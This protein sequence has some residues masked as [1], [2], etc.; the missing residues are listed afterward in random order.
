MTKCDDP[1]VGVRSGTQVTSAN[2]RYFTPRVR[3]HEFQIDAFGNAIIRA[4]S[5]IRRYNRRWNREMQ[6]RVPA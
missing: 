4:R 3:H 1:N 5:I 6:R 2:G